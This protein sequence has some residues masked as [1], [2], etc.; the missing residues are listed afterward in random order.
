MSARKAHRVLSATLAVAALTGTMLLTE[1]GAA[2]AS[3]GTTIVGIAAAN[4]NNGPTST[5]SAG[6]SGYY[7]SAGENWCADFAKWVWAQD[8]VDVTGLT[9]GAGSFANYGARLHQTPQVGDAAVFDFDGVSFAKHVAIVTSVNADGSVSTIGGNQ[10]TAQVLNG[11]VTRGTITSGGYFSTEHVS[12][13]VSPIGGRDATPSTSASGAGALAASATGSSVHLELVGSD[14]AQYNND[15]NYATGA[16]STWTKMDSSNLRSIASVTIGNVD[17]IFAVAAD[18]A[19]YSRDADY[20]AGT[21]GNW[22]AVPGSASGAK[23]VS[24][25]ASNG[26]VH[27]SLI[28]SDGALYDNEGNYT[29]GT[30]STWTKMDTSNLKSV[31]SATVGNV[32]H[33]FAVAADGGVYSRD[34]NYDTGV[35]GA[36]GAVPG[37]AGGAKAVSAS[38]SNGVVHMSLIGSDGALYDNEANYITGTWST[39]TKMDSSNLKSISSTTVGNVNHI[40]AVAADGGVYSRDVNYDTGTWGTWSVVPGGASA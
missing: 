21:W 9:A 35:W 37:G 39:W 32:N 27:L 7:G 24:A 36:W 14:G 11:Q 5:N 19:V 38:A 10:N 28:G 16:W 18:G 33:I 22:V 29:T 13:Y 34:V 20:S 1:A 26:V 4:L 17:H 8:G 40:F 31:S 23:A 15:G 6:G 30:W 25:S 12:G 3:V 2:S